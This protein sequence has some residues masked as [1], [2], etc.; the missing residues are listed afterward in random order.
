M[1]AIYLC[2]SFKT[3]T[4]LIIHCHKTK[5]VVAF[6]LVLGKKLIVL[7]LSNIITKYLKRFINLHAIRRA[8]SAVTIICFCDLLFA[9]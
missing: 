7:Y 2:S 6:G 3:L 8:I 4:V 1:C 9:R 5:T